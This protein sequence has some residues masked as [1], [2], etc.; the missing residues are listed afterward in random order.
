MGTIRT[1]IRQHQP[2]ECGQLLFSLATTV[3]PLQPRKILQGKPAHWVDGIPSKFVN[4]WPSW[5]LWPAWERI[6]PYMTFTVMNPTYPNRDKVALAHVQTP[7]WGE[8]KISQMKD[9]I[10]S[11]WLGHAC[12][13]VELPARPSDSRGVRILFDPVFSKRCSSLQAIGPKRFTPAPCTVDK[14]PDLD[15]IVISHDHYDHMDSD[16]LRSIFKRTRKPL[17]FAP[18]GNVNFMKSIGAPPETTHIM[19][20]WHSKRVEIQIPLN[21]P[22]SDAEATKATFTTLSFDITCTPCQHFTGRKLWD[23]FQTLWS[24]WAIE[25]PS[26]SIPNPVPGLDSTPV[27]TRS[28]NISPQL[29]NDTT[30]QSV[31]VFFAG[32]TGYRA[33]NDDEDEDK[34]PCCPAFKE[35]GEVFGGFDFAMIPIGAYQ[36]RRVMSPIHCAPQDSVRIFKDIRARKALGMHWGAWI[37]TTEPVDEPPKKLMEECRKVDIPVKDFGVCDIGETRFW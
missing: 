6:L 11:T 12:F 15:V 24:S 25:A 1:T 10:K 3:T 20:W 2:S 18:L 19:D 26:V 36:P 13:L 30:R 5:R 16:T 23:D 33:V 21:S 9:K 22:P 4:P 32:D 7:N 27:D 28:E 8:D 35:I 37:L 34:V 31:K 14:I 29:E 17:V